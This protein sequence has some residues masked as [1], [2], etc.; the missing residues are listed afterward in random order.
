MEVNPMVYKCTNM[1]K[2][3]GILRG[4]LFIVELYINAKCFYIKPS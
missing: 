3:I 2:T 4:I 1:K